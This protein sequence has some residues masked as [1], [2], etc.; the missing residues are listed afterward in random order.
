MK[1]G[2]R[3]AAHFPNTV[4]TFVKRANVELLFHSGLF[5]VLG[6]VDRS[7]Q[8]KKQPNSHILSLSIQLECVP[9]R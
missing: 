3:F 7:Y 5:V 8:N 2:V 4:Y 9:F 6:Y 1:T